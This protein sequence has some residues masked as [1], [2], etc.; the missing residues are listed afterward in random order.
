MSLLKIGAAMALYGKKVILLV[1]RGVALPSNLQ[2]LYRCNFEGEKLDYDATMKLL[3]TFQSIPVETATRSTGVYNRPLQIK[4]ST[5]PHTAEGY[6]RQGIEGVYNLH[7]YEKECRAAL[8][9][10]QRYLQRIVEAK[11]GKVVP[12]RKEGQ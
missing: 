8:E 5:A 6:R 10:W 9:K 1:Q 7:S 4:D 2:R 12:I 11:P 3:K